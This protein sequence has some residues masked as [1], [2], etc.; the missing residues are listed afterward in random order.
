MVPGCCQWPP[1]RPRSLLPVSTGAG[2]SRGEDRDGQGAEE[3][4]GAAQQG[5]GQRS[6]AVRGL[7]PGAAGPAERPQKDGERAEEDADDERDAE[8]HPNGIG[9]QCDGAVAVARPGARPWPPAA[10]ASASASAWGAVGHPHPAVRLRRQRHGRRRRAPTRRDGRS[11]VEAAKAKKR[12]GG[13]PWCAPGWAAAG[14]G[15]GYGPHAGGRGGR[16]GRGGA[17]WKRR[18]G[19]LAL[20][21]H[22][23]PPSWRSCHRKTGP[24]TAPW[25]RIR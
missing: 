1:P 8:Q 2:A 3:Q 12:R 17:P 5:T 19:F 9:D 13:V 23:T 7:A 20:F 4:G 25:C 6:P 24:R 16:G 10:R 18:L 14:H 21:G 11:G 22:G 15:P